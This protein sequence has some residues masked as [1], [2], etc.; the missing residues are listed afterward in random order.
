M[1]TA[2]RKFPAKAGRTHAPQSAAPADAARLTF[3]V[4]VGLKRVLGRELIT[5]D[6]VAI[7]E[8]VKNAFDAGARQVTLR[9][10]ADAITV[11]DDGRGMSRGDLEEK[12]LFVAYSEKRRG[13]HPGQDDYRDHA[14][15][16]RQYAGSK[17]IGRFSADRLGATLTL[18]T[19]KRGESRGPVHRLDV[20]WAQF[21]Q[22]DTRQFEQVRVQY[23]A[24]PGFVVPDGVPAPRHGT[25]LR[26]GDLAKAWDRKALQRLRAGLSKLINPFGAAADGFRIVLV[27]P[28]EASEDARDWDRARRKAA[29]RGEEPS[30]EPPPSVVNGPVGNF[31][32]SDLRAKTTHLEVAIDGATGDLTSTLTDRGEVIYRIREPN[33]Y[34]LLQDARFRCQLFYLNHAAKTTF[35]RRTGV[36]SVRFGSVFLFRNGFRV[37]PV[38]EEGDDYFQID[39]RKQQGYARFLGTRELIGRIDIEGAGDE[40]QEGS[41]R[42]SGLIAT[43][44]VAE[45]KACFREH[46]L[47]RLEHY[48]VPVTWT[49]KADADRETLAGLESDSGRA[50]VTAAVADLV[51]GEDIELLEYSERLVGILNERSEEFEISLTSL[52]AIA[53]STGDKGLVRQITRA[54]RRFAELKRTEAE[55]RRV[56]DA[57]RAAKE[58]AEA[59]AESAEAAAASATEQLGEERKRNLFLTSIGTLDTETILN[60]HHQITIY[61]TDLQARVANLLG[62]ARRGG[63][64]NGADAVAALE[65]IALLNHK[66]LAVAQFATK[67]NFRLD[68]EAIDADLAAY[69]TEYIT[70]VTRDFLTGPTRAEVTSDGRAFPMRFKPIDVSIVV[71]NLISNA[72][73]ARATLVQFSVSQP[74]KGH[75]HVLVTD[76]GRGVPPEAAAEGRLF[77][78]GFTTTSGS[79]L[80]LYHVRQVLGELGGSIELAEAP[81]RGAAFLIRVARRSAA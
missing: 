43:P 42:N 78:K 49:D 30:D 26:I 12:W 53:A 13:R 17:G 27:A 21:D 32:F 39:R 4:G 11:A 9:F 2:P 55:A 37:F 59:R 72:Q 1:S 36:A 34:P 69:L 57:E 46:V 58:A 65:P 80:G 47:K 44:A 7:F 5:D 40:F 67:A 25:V 29:A 41:S 68:S 23:R 60:M 10:D 33:P 74:R 22:D 31:I 16:H 79:G 54:E 56:A 3:R 20:N 61:A 8:L 28:G 51:G 48:V 70:G 73:R 81:A 62:R 38:G 19:R 14:A 77:E 66:V 35:A 15:D 52:R 71:D 6:D 75:L 76:D 18:Q 64:L 63:G 45:L 50:R 24:T